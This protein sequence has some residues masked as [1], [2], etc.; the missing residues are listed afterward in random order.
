[1]N[2]SET[3]FAAPISKSV[4][5]I[6]CSLFLCDWNSFAAKLN[7]PRRYNAGVTAYQSNDFTQA[8]TAFESATASTDRA[9]QERA[10]YNLGDATYRLGQEQPAQAQQLWQRAIKYYESALALNPRDADAHFNQEFVK[11]KLEE[12]KKQQQQQHQNQESQQDKK[13]EQN[14]DE[15][16]GQE[17]KQ[18]QQQQNSKADQSEE[19]KQQQSQ[20]SPEQKQEQEQRDKQQQQQAQQQ[21]SDQPEQKPSEKL[22]EPGNYDKMQATAL[23]NDLR[24]NEQN[25]NF[26]PEVQMKELKDSGAPV[27]DW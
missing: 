26:F 23:L 20:Q 9:L 10:L 25:W 13:Q 18:D 19:Q 27:K 21:K 3:S 4:L 16:K 17:K 24:E 8:A 12:L 7:E 11:K 2:Y 6:F 14:K 5:F 15:Q 22:G 1:M